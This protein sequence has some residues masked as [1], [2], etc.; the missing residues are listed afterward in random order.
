M[1]LQKRAI[2]SGFNDIDD[3]INFLEGYYKRVEREGEINNI[4]KA[5]HKLNN[6]INLINL[7]IDILKEN[8][9]K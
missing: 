4:I 1:N 8:I 3:Y 9:N 6:K 7:K 2:K 5:I